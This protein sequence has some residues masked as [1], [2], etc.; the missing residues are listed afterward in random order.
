MA[1]ALPSLAGCVACRRPFACW[2]LVTPAYE[3]GAQVSPDGKWLLYVSNESGPLEVFMRPM[4]GPDPES[5]RCRAA[6]ARTPRGA[7]TAGA[8]SFAP[9]RKIFAVDLTTTTEVHLGAPEFLFEK[10]QAFG[11]NL[12]IPNYSLSADGREFL[13]VREE[14]GGRHLSIVLN[15]LRVARGAPLSHAAEPRR[16]ARLV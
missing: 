5:I 8:S 12:T 16:E 10:R 14:P 13:M 6:A 2:R 15:W 7:A 9:G 3:G 1:T 11:Q 4:S